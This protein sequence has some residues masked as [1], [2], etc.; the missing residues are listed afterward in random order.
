MSEMLPFES[1]DEAIADVKRH[2]TNLVR[3]Y[4]VTMLK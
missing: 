3:I 1:S 2:P 4:S